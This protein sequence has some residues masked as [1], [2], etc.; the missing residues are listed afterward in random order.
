MRRSAVSR[1]W[2]ILWAVLQFA[3]PAGATLA[4]ARLAQASISTP[5]SHVESSTSSACVPSH[6]D[7]CALCQV[8]SRVAAPS[9]AAALP[10]IVDAL[11]PSPRAAVPC[12]AMRALARASLPRAPPHALA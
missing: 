6:P 10:T 12:A 1:G 3:L 7:E 9:S 4:D 11:A 8:V 5:G 2:A